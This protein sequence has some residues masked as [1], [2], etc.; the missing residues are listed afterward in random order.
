MKKIMKLLSVSVLIALG[1]L[2][3][4]ACQTKKGL[5]KE[6][7]FSVVTTIY[8]EY[9][10]VKTL[11]RGQQGRYE[12]T[13]LLDN[14]ADLHSYQ[15][16]ANDIITIQDCDMFI[17]VGGESDEWV[18]DVL[19][20]AKNE[21]MVVINLME[22]LGDAVKEEEVV[23]GM[24][25]EEEEEEGEEEEAEKDEH[26]WLSL[27]NAK[28]CCEAI[29]DGLEKIDH[30]NQSDYESRL[31]DLKAQMDK[32]D[33]EYKEVVRNAKTKTVLFGDRFP[34]RYLTDDYGLTYY[35][36]FVGCSAESEASFK[37]VLFLAEKVDEEKLSTILTL[38]SSDDKLANTIREN[39]KLK[40]QK[41]LKMNS[42][43]SVTKA[44]VDA[45]LSYIDVMRD[46]L[47]VLKEALN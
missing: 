35:A 23:E 40:N 43:Q 30:E 38:E 18:E 36:A 15:P 20:G 39:T 1:I 34:F 24:E 25:A 22:V 41:I 37:T 17:Y 32:L 44:D 46:N 16:S 31:L 7:V 3:L 27:S 10:W 28:I 29:T 8:P 19:A 5:P 9:D 42:L 47:E 11:T 13:L 33:E 6:E 21:N 45:G 14:G 26:V 12:I 4:S 2:M